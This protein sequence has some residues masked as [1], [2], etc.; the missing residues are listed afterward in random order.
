MIAD[1]QPAVAK[2]AFAAGA[3]LIIGHHAH[4]PKAIEV[5]DGKACFYSLGN[6]ILST[7]PRTPEQAAE[8]AHRSHGVELDPDYP[9]LPFGIDSKRTLITRAVLT[10]DGVKR[11]SFIPAIIDKQLRP[12]II[13]H[14][15]PRFADMVRF[16]EWVSEG[17]EHTF[18]IDGD[19]VVVT[20]A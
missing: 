1:Y 16:M 5:F 9:M 15:D 8:F 6:F 19:E 3:D 12:E 10:K 11:V 14:D 18:T 17:R 4:V 20:G 7:H 2:A 13:R